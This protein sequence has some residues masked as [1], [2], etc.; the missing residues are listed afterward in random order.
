MTTP[1]R[2]LAV[3]VARL[4]DAGERRDAARYAKDADYRLGWDDGLATCRLAAFRKT[5]GQENI[6]PDAGIHW[7][8]D[9]RRLVAGRVRTLR[10]QV[11]RQAIRLRDWRRE[12]LAVRHR[13]RLLP[14]RRP[15]GAA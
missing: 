15:A 2:P 7:L 4:T 3:R 12:W 9:E 10:R 8:N 11:A 14:P 1:R 5:R 6:Q 13:E